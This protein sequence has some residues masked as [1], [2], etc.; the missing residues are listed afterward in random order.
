MYLFSPVAIIIANKTIIIA[1]L[2]TATVV[3]VAT[4]CSKG[5]C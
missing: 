2:A 4:S 1:T 3:T 5:V